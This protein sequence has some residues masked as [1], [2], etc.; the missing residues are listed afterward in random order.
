MWCGDVVAKS[1]RQDKD[2]KDKHTQQGRKHTERGRG[3]KDAVKD[4]RAHKAGKKNTC[5]HA[6]IH[7]HAHAKSKLT[8]QF[9][10]AKSEFSELRLQVRT[11]KVKARKQNK[12]KRGVKLKGVCASE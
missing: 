10:G 1:C 4:A 8:G 2:T 9:G 12:L 11:Y 5:A 7:V 3:D 6:C